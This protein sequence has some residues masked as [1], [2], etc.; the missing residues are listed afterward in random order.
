MTSV[1]IDL[2][3]AA[4]ERLQ[5]KADDAGMTLAELLLR[6]ALE[7]SSDS[8]ESPGDP[9]GFVGIGASETVQSA[10]GDEHLRRHG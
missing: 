4:A 3:D 1:A 6:M 10:N 7:A 2:D 5:A 8:G 9:Y